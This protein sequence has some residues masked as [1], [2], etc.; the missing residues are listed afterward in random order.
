MKIIL[1]GLPYFVKKLAVELNDFHKSIKFIPLDINGSMVDKLKFLWHIPTAKVLY[2]HSGGIDRSFA[3]DIALFLRKKVVMNWAGTDVLK[4]IKNYKA[5]RY[6]A[7]HITKVK[8]YCVAPWLK[9][10]LATIGVEAELLPVTVLNKQNNINSNF[11]E[12]FTVLT[13]IGKNREKFY[14]IDTVIKLADDFKDIDFRVAG[15]DGYKGLKCENIKFLGWIDDMQKEYANCSVFLRDTEHD[16][17]P[18]SVIEALSFGKPVLFNKKYPYVVYFEGYEDLTSKL[19]KLIDLHN[20][21]ELK[22]NEE[23]KAF[24]EDEFNREKVLGNFIKTLKAGG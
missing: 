16:G 12:K 10:E 15:I 14:G 3:T 4:A 11:P 8:H 7:G 1:S 18:F 23:A 9:E 2:F 19:K 20:K 22:I 17:M 21:G 5:G 13:Y 24:V 6:K